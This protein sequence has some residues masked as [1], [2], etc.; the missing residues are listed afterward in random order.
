MIVPE[1]EGLLPEIEVILPE[2][3]AMLPEAEGFVQTLPGIGPDTVNV[4]GNTLPRLAPNLRDLALQ[5]R[6]IDNL[7]DF[8][9]NNPKGAFFLRWANASSDWRFS[10]RST[11]S[12]DALRWI[13]LWADSLFGL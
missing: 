8:L 2:A 4:L 5:A 1:W 10:L 9:T 7:N 11:E 12:T 3:E 6:Y 13:S